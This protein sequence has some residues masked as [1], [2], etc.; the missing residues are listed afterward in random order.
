MT[1]LAISVIIPT[2]GHNDALATLVVQLIKSDIFEI[3]IIK[4]ENTEL[5]FKLP[6]SC[7]CL[8]APKGRGSQ[9]QAGLDVAKGD[10]LWILHDV[11]KCSCLKISFISTDKAFISNPSAIFLHRPSVRNSK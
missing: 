9:I 1:P 4:P 10:I 2:T 3:I 7:K 11:N 5:R 8:A 6:S